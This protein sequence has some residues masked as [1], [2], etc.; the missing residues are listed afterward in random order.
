MDL[1]LPSNIDAERSVL[2][3][4]L[5]DSNSLKKTHQA[6]LQPEDFFHDAHRR[7]FRACVKMDELKLTIDTLT[8]S[9]YL[10]STH[11]LETCGGSVFISNLIDGIPRLSN[12]AHYAALVKEKSHLRKLAHLGEE[13][14]QRIL[15]S[16]D[17][18]DIIQAIQSEQAVSKNIISSVALKIA[19]MP[20]GVL[21]GVLG[22]ICQREMKHFPI[23]YAW[24]ALVAVAGAILPKNGS[25][26]RS[27]LYVGLIGPI[28]SG[29]TQAEEYARKLIGI[30]PPRLQSVMS[31]SAEGLLGKIKNAEGEGRLVC[32][33]ELGHLF[34]KASIE[35]ASFPYILNRAFYQSEFDLTTARGKIVH[36]DSC[37]SLLGGIVEGDFQKCFDS[38]T[39][40]GLHDRFIFGVCPDPFEFDYRPFEGDPETFPS[41]PAAPYVEKEVWEMKKQWLAE[42][43]ALT[44]R[45]AEIALRVAG[46]CAAFD[47][48][49]VL[50]VADLGPALVFARHQAQTRIVFQPNPGENPDARCSFAVISH[51]QQYEGWVN[52]HDLYRKIH[53]HRFGPG[54]YN[55]VLIQLAQAGEIELGSKN[56]EMR[57]M[58]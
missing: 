48:K 57:R 1:A 43:K 22:E 24:P 7:V 8:V 23:A 45:V 42:N 52:C 26:L 50:C 58:E 30:E 51:L 25:P 38:G 47:G 6:H 34:S 16:D 27:N 9:D 15:H 55:R 20:D 12:I 37:L 35:N 11:E 18:T 31:G 44:P 49:R 19:D 39:I 40:G 56:K 54:I 41:V 17:P 36:F 53:A 46:I 14:K 2:G 29:K 13:L 32:P 5:L 33:D 21:E 3:A 28:H 4:I 10:Q